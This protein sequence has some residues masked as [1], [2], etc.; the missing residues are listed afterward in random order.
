MYKNL[1]MHV[2]ITIIYC[3]HWCTTDM[4]ICF[5]LGNIFLLNIHNTVLL[6]IEDMLQCL[7]MEVCTGKTDD[8]SYCGAAQ[9]KYSYYAY[10]MSVIAASYSNSCSNL[11]ILSTQHIHLNRLLGGTSTTISPYLKII[12]HQR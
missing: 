7:T 8:N 6:Q 9:Y 10:L 4:V 1:F 11:H 2:H 5:R 12:I 3:I